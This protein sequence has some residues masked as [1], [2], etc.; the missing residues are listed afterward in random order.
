VAE[1]RASGLSSPRFCAGKEY[2]AG[3]LRHWAHLLSHGKGSGL[4]VRVAKVV[5]LSRLV[6]A[7]A[8]V[9]LPAG[10]DLV[11]EVGVARV[12][13]RPGFDRALLAAVL[14]ELVTVAARSAR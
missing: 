5:R 14:E 3:G 2:T 4:P 8:A 11:V 7:T 1:W 13:V 9:P 10:R 12:V 6:P